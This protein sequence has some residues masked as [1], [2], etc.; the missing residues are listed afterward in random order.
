MSSLKLPAPVLSAACNLNLS[1]LAIGEGLVGGS[2]KVQVLRDSGC[3]GIVIKSSLV[4]E[5]QYTGETEKCYLIDMTV[6]EFPLARI[7]I[8]T[9][10]YTGIVNAMVT[11]TPVCELVVGSIKGARGENDPDPDFKLYS[12][13]E[14]DTTQRQFSVEKKEVQKTEVSCAVETRSQTLK[15][16]KPFKGLKV[17]EPDGEEVTVEKLKRA[18]QEDLTLNRCRALA[19]E[20]IEKVGRNDSKQMFIIEKGVLYRQFQAPNVEFGDTFKQVVVPQTFR[21]QVMKLAHESILG[22]HQGPS[23]TSDK[24]LSNFYWPGAQADIR[25]YC[26]SCDICQRTIP[27]G[28]VT[29]VPLGEMPVIDTPFE[30]VAVDLVGPIHPCSDRGHRYIIVLVDYATRYPEASPMKSIEAEKVAEELVVM[31]TRLGFPREVLTDMGAQ[32]TSNVMKE[33]SR[34]LSIK[35]LTTT[36]YHPAC[37]GLVERFNGTLKALLKKICEERPKDW[38]RYVAPLLFAY[39]ETPQD[40]TGFAPFELL[41]GR[42]VRGPMSILRQLWTGE[43]ETPET[44]SVYQYVIDLKERLEETCKLARA[45]LL[46]SKARYRKIYNRK[47]RSRKFAV[48]DEVLLLL[49]TDHNKLIMHWKG[50]FPVVEKVSQL[51]YKIDLG[52]RQQTFHANLLKYYQ[53]RKGEIASSCIQEEQGIFQVV[54]TSV[55]EAEPLE[56]DEVLKD[57]L[58]LKPMSNEELL[59]LPP[60]EPKESVSDV[61]IG[62]NLDE[63]QTN[64]VKRLLGSYHEVLT[65]LPGKTNLG[66]HEIKLIDEEPVKRKPYPIPHALRDKVKEEVQTMLKMGI[67][68]RSNSPYASPLVICK[69]SDGSD[70]YCID[71]RLINQKTIFD[72]EPIADQEEIFAKLATDHYFTKIDLSK[73]YWQIPMA[74]SSK[75]YTAFVT[76][77]GLYSLKMMPFGLVNAPA[78]FSRIM[79]ILLEGVTKVDNYIDDIL[80]HTETWEEHM[81]KVKEVFSRLRRAKLTARPTKCF[82]GYEEIEFLG[83]VVGHGCV[84][85][86]RDKIEVIQDAKCPVTKKQLRS[87]W[88]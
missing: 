19:E 10:W 24:V 73:G 54:C 36:P 84:K 46:K 37:N 14:V 69:K 25:R 48:G 59:H 33:V 40:S 88:D 35:Q 6:R 28:R 87:F 60:L 29:K 21:T 13:E 68:E 52:T 8:H 76:P 34:L 39:R 4:S 20:R 3:G 56:K 7:S 42:T 61:H 41:Y 79:R 5:E 77:N 11:A 74:E 32:F 1:D 82:V 2:T 78:T 80:I 57:T 70:R 45:E 16:G 55:I 58:V 64:A 53:R 67:I 47:A 31:F 71:M 27:K 43:V 66:E 18:Q 63:T 50:P 65:D 49:P 15:K 75:K 72:A 30:R 23:K 17:V 83:H 51:D 85:P 22:G 9:P 81:S 12:S 26:H 44:K 86:K 38:D 62:E